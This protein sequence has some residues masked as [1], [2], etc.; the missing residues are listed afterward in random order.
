MPDNIVAWVGNYYILDGH[1]HIDGLEVVR[2]R[3][4]LDIQRERLDQGFGRWSGKEG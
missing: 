1:C 2:N 3:N 4:T